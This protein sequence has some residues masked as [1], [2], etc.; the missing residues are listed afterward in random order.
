MSVPYK[1][2]AKDR[3]VR[4]RRMNSGK[5]IKVGTKESSK[6]PKKG[7]RKKKKGPQ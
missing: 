3:T 4:K 5:E 6:C 2:N 1:E 7:V